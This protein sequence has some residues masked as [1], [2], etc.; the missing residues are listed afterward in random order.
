MELIAREVYTYPLLVHSLKKIVHVC[1][2]ARAFGSAREIALNILKL[3]V[4]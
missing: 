2:I 1:Q 4:R 3:H